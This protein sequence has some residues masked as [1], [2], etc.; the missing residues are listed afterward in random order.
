MLT[1]EECKFEK[2]L[3]DTN[4]VF[5]RKCL[6]EMHNM[7]NCPTIVEESVDEFGN[8]PYD[9]QKYCG[10]TTPNLFYQK[11]C[12]K[13]EKQCLDKLFTKH[14]L[15]QYEKSNEKMKYFINKWK[16]SI[17]TKTNRFS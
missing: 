15:Y 4:K 1:D 9:F 8:L 6:F 2:D 17:Y 3:V 13:S 12:D 11:R 14:L 10:G 16:E 7:L 5:N